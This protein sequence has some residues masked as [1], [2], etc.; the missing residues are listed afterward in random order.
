MLGT[1]GVILSLLYG[2]SVWLSGGRG[3]SRDRCRT[4]QRLAELDCRT[5]TDLEDWWQSFMGTD[6]HLLLRGR[7][8]SRG[9]H[10]GDVCRTELSIVGRFWHSIRRE[11]AWTIPEV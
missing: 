4:Q 8:N 9:P 1:P 6:G 10:C 3:R 2:K 7:H 11:P 5:R